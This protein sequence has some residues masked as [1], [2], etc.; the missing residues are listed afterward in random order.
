MELS[1]RFGTE[2]HA[3]RLDRVQKSLGPKSVEFSCKKYITQE[4][5][6]IIALKIIHGD[7]I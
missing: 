6:D 2:D 7:L 1:A 3:Q 4:Y 5:P